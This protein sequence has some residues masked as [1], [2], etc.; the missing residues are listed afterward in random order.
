MSPLRV[1]FRPLF[2]FFG[3]LVLLVGCAGPSTPEEKVAASRASYTVQLNAFLEQEPAVE[4]IVIEEVV[5]EAAEAGAV[6]TAMVA[7]EAAVA[8]EESGEGEEGEAGEESED[9]LSSDAPR[10]ASILFDILVVFEGDDALPGITVEISHADPFEKE[11]A[12][13]REYLETGP[14]LGGETKQM[15]VIRE[16]EDFVTGDVFSV[17]MRPSVPAEEY[18]DYREFSEAAP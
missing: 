17:E 5:E 12:V 1:P 11:K 16:I 10:S 4:E 15:T 18:G 14:M 13:Y 6:A 3:L 2:V 7:E 9:V 8:A